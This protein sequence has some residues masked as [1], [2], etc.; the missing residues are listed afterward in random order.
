LLETKTMARRIIKYSNRRLYDATQART[1]TLVELSEL[2]A[3][4]ESVRVER[5]GS[6][7]DITGVTLLQSVLERLKRSPG[8]PM[9]AAVLERLLAAARSAIE[10]AAQRAEQFD[11]GVGKLSPEPTPLD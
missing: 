2:V 6:G 1:I 3:R 8:D 11:Q 10:Q 7:E 5:K 4:G 9:G